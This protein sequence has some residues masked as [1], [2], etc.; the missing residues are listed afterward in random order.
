LWK[1]AQIDWQETGGVWFWQRAVAGKAKSGYIITILFTGLRVHAGLPG[2]DFTPAALLRHRK[3]GAF[4]LY[5]QAPF[6]HL[7]SLIVVC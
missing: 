2:S 5:W 3:Q 6:P 4:I 7:L 1:T